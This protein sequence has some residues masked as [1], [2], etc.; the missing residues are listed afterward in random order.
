MKLIFMFKILKSV[1]YFCDKVIIEV[2]EPCTKSVTSI[3][4][5]QYSFA[6]Y[7]HYT[8]RDRNEVKTYILT[9]IWGLLC[10]EISIQFL[11]R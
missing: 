4:F 9:Y 8:V 3:S 7:Y 1:N 10:L 6:Y 5:K 11:R 2:N